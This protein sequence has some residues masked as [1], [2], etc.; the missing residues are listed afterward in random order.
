MG[1]VVCREVGFVLLHPPSLGRRDVEGV[2]VVVIAIPS[3][4]QIH[5]SE[6]CPEPSNVSAA[7][8]CPFIVQRLWVGSGGVLF[9]GR[10]H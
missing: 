5:V 10:R 8:M 4:E 2:V 9:I 3:I 1:R 6:G 7:L